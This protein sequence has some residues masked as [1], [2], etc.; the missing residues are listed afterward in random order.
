[1]PAEGLFRP[2][3][4]VVPMDFIG[5]YAFYDDGW[6]GALTLSEGSG[7]GLNASFHSYR[8]DA[9]YRATALVGD[10]APNEIVVRIRDFNELEEQVF[11][12]YLFTRTKNAIAGQ[13]EW[14]GVPFGFYGRR[15]RPRQVSPFGFGPLQPVDFA[16]TYSVYCDG[17]PATVHLIF[18][19]GSVLSGTWRWTF[20]GTA[21]PVAATVGDGVAHRIDLSIPGAGSPLFTG[22]LF[23]RPKNVVAGSIDHAETR[24]GCYMLR[25]E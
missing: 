3:D 19:Q 24:L 5:R 16:G 17:E 9:D 8:F 4:P 11:T 23:T 6:L 15:S 1:M 12:G 18:E 14:K 7:G 22:Y 21:F 2:P 20:D 10:R 13:T 25:F